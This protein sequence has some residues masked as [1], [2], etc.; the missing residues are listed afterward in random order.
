MMGAGC[1]K[2]TDKPLPLL[3]AT[4]VRG[5]SCGCHT[6]EP[7]PLPGIW[8]CLCRLLPRPGPLLCLGWPG[9]FPLHSVFQEVWTPR[10]L[11]F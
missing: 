10:P 9:L 2:A 8:G 1:G 5:L 4:T 7:A 6:P 11:E 3:S